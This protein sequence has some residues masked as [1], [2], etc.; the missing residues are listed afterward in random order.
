MRWCGLFSNLFLILVSENSIF[1]Q[2][3]EFFKN[4]F[5]KYLN[6]NHQLDDK[7]KFY[8]NKIILT[9]TNK[10]HELVIYEDEI[11]AISAMLEAEKLDKLE[12][13]FRNKKS[14]HLSKRELDSILISS[15]EIYSLNRKNNLPLSGIRI[16]IDPGHFAAD[17]NTAKI[18]Q[19]LLHFKHPVNNKIDTITLIEGKLTYQTAQILADKLKEQ[20]AEILITRVSANST[21]FGMSFEEWWK[22][23]K[24]VV[25]DSLYQINEISK[26][27]YNKLKGCSKQ[28]FFNLFFREYELLQRARI[29]NNFNPHLTVIIH[30]NVDEK[31]NPWNKATFNNYSMCFIGGAFEANDLNRPVN[32]IHFLRLL[33]TNQIENSKKISAYTIR[34]F[35]NKLNIVA[36]KKND[37]NYLQS[38]CIPS[39]ERGVYCRN[40]LLTR[41]IISPLVYGESMCQDNYKEC[42]LLS[43]NNYLYKSTKIPYRIYE[44]AEA[45]FNAIMNY[46]NDLHGN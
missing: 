8:D 23:R 45:Y 12:L 44:V 29:I 10:E 40:L 3:V 31:N 20:G 41:Y 4:R 1:S 17:I 25:L 14:R 11:P 18:E 35:E 13:F 36:A 42:Q 43:Q 33:L 15:N 38:V 32:V 37:A 21:A 24:D 28:Q 30:Y 34:N 16:A 6:L 26:E 39:E 9:L 5:D 22:K 2:N 27:K 7:V 46:F 19:R